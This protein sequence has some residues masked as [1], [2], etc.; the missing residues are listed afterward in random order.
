VLGALDAVTFRGPARPRPTLVFTVAEGKTTGFVLD[1]GDRRV[2]Y[3][4]VAEEPP[5]EKP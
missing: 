3:T 5:K 1:F 2:P 4:R